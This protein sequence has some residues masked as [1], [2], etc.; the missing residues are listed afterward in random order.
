[1]E[2]RGFLK[3]ILGAAVAAAGGFYGWHPELRARPKPLAEWTI[4]H[5]FSTG[6]TGAYSRGE[7]SALAEFNRT[8]REDLGSGF[9]FE[10]LTLPTL[11]QFNRIGKADPR[12]AVLEIMRRRSNG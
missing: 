10:E 12:P 8:I 4:K 2:R 5:K 6:I 3:S 9:E 11:A 7:L 1:M